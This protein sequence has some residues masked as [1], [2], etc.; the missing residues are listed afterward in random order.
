QHSFIVWDDSFVEPSENVTAVHNPC[1]D[2]VERELQTELPVGACLNRDDAAPIQG[3]AP[4]KHLFNAIRIADVFV[5]SIEVAFQVNLTLV[6]VGIC[7]FDSAPILLHFFYVC[8]NLEGIF[9][10]SLAA[11][12]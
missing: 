3:R 2:G 1:L 6:I 12:L 4:A 7:Q 11:C 8:S 5:I 9:C 10:Y